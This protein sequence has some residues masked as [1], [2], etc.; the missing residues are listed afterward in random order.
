MRERGH[1]GDRPARTTPWWH[2]FVVG[3]AGD[4]GATLV[5]HPADV[6]KVR[7]QLHGEL[8]RSKPRLRFADVVGVTRGLV[9]ESGM[10]RVLYRGIGAALARHAVFSSLRHGSYRTVEEQTS[11]FSGWRM[12]FLS[13]VA[14]AVAAG[15]VAGAVANPLDVV[16]VRMQ[17]TS[18]A[19]R[20]GYRNV[21]HGLLSVVREE[22]ALAL[23]RGC[24]PTVLRASLVTASQ[25]VSYRSAADVLRE[26]AG[27]HG[28]PLHVCS[29]MAS[30]TV[31]CLATSPV[32]VVKTRIMRSRSAGAYSGA[33]DCVRQTLRT[34]GPPAFYK[35]LS[36]TFARL[37]PHTVMVWLIQEQCADMLQPCVP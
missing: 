9:A 33:L 10:P 16:L 26:R 30:G 27:L 28:T 31:A 37:W 34:E 20:R 17:A 7:L 23:W 19:D 24:G 18:V 2:H 14:C 3:A 11:S 6:L 8:H 21:A 15:A 25:I 32:D 5:S 1:P 22:G 4:M 36:A 35:G 12:R 29:G 13:S